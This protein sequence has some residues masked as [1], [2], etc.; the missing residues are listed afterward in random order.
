MYGVWGLQTAKGQQREA[1]LTL[2]LCACLWLCHLQSRENC[3][4][5]MGGAQFWKYVRYV[6]PFLRTLAIINNNLIPI[7][8]V[9]LLNHPLV[10][11]WH[12][13]K[14]S[15]TTSCA[16]TAAFAI[17]EGGE[18][19]IESRKIWIG[20]SVLL[21]MSRIH[22]G[23]PFCDFWPWFLLLCLSDR[24]D[25]LIITFLLDNGDETNYLPF[26]RSVRIRKHGGLVSFYCHSR[27]KSLG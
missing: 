6:E 7:L 15:V 5:G 4:N 27:G 13:E 3:R 19:R 21:L 14:K 17:D 11:M 16:C 9:H 8:S 23:K 2:A 25:W 24:A 26:L 12:G 18:Q 10:F 1:C 22:L 20:A